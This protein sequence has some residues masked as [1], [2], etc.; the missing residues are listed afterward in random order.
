ML[1]NPI[2]FVVLLLHDYIDARINDDYMLFENIRDWTDK[3]TENI[4]QDI[5]GNQTLAGFKLNDGIGNRPIRD[6]NSG[7]EMRES[8]HQWAYERAADIVEKSYVDG[9]YK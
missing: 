6:P 8:I 5:F 2:K 9:R 7:I 4:F 1:S 3:I